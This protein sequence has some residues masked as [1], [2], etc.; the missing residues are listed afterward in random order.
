MQTFII[1]I[2]R[3][4]NVFSN[5]NVVRFYVQA[6]IYT[7]HVIVYSMDHQKNIDQLAVFAAPFNTIHTIRACT[8][9]AMKNHTTLMILY[10]LSFNAV[11]YFGSLN[12][13]N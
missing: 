11:W 5:V 9:D 12:L 13:L 8:I 4:T 1:I 2:E 3:M 7:Q 6:N 10:L